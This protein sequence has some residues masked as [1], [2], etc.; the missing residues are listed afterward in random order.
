MNIWLTSVTSLFQ[1]SSYKHIREIQCLVTILD[2]YYEKM[3]DS[4]KPRSQ[5]RNKQGKF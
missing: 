5:Y 2:F 3:P 1:S 4:E